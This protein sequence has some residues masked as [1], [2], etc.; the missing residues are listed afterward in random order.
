M[1]AVLCDVVSVLVSKSALYYLFVFGDEV[2][3][4]SLINVTRF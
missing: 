2:S 1:C 3:K 4:S